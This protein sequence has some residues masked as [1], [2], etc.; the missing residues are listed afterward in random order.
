MGKR[1]GCEG[2]KFIFKFEGYWLDAQKDIGWQIIKI[3]AGRSE[4]VWFKY[5][6]GLGL[7][8]RQPEL[9]TL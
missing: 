6:K 1:D 3:W 2:S 7:K 8:I 9:H 5:Q 4:R